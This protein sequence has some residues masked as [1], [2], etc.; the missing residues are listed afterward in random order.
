MAWPGWWPGPWCWRWWRWPASCGGRFGRPASAHG[1]GVAPVRG[2]ARSHRYSVCLGRSADP[3]GAGV[4]AN[5]PQRGPEGSGQ[6]CTLTRKL[7]VFWS[8]VKASL[9]LMPYL[10]FQ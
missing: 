4:P 10:F 3:V 7:M 2:H 9:S 8:V 5:G 6:K 1:R